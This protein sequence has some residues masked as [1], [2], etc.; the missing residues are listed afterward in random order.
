MRFSYGSRDAVDTSVALAGTMRL[1]S[2]LHSA[3]GLA[4]V[5]SADDEKG[6]NLTTVALILAYFIS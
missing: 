6:A 3:A 2:P 4:S 5:L 1:S